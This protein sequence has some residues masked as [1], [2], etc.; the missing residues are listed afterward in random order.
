MIAISPLSPLTMTINFIA[1]REAKSFERE[2]GKYGESSFALARVV[3]MAFNCRTAEIRARAQRWA[4]ETMNM[5]LC[6]D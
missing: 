1:Q 2:I 3:D 6:A 5:R 4:L